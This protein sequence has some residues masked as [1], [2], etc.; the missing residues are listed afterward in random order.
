MREAN[1]L[2]SAESDGGESYQPPH[3]RV[4]INPV[5][6]GIDDPRQACQSRTVGGTVRSSTLRLI[7]RSVLGT[8][9][10]GTLQCQWPLAAG[11]L[12]R[13]PQMTSWFAS[14]CRTLLILIQSLR[15]DGRQRRDILLLLVMAGCPV[16]A[17][18]STWTLAER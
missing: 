9:P 2:N 18:M 5:R 8:W 12:L 16:R 11:E 13:R 3:G 10:G 17:I 15:L 1:A 7:T 6:R 4:Q 14:W